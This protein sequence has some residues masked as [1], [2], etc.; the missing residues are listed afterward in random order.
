[1]GRKRVFINLDCHRNR[2]LNL[3][4]YAFTIFRAGSEIIRLLKK[5]NGLKYGGNI[6]EAEK[7]IKLRCSECGAKAHPFDTEC[8]NCGKE[9]ET[10][11]E[12]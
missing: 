6:S 8:D 12:E 7:I 5:L 4:N 9:F 11:K 2:K 3:G 10:H 1:M